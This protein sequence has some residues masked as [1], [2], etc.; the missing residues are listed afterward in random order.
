MSRAAEDLVRR[1]VDAMVNEGDLD[2]ADEVFS[3]DLAAE[4]RRWVA[5]FRASFTDV[6]MRVVTLVVDGDQV[7]GRFHCSGTHTGTWLGHPPT[8]R[9]FDDVD[10][11][12]FFRVHDARIVEM[13]G[14][15]DTAE[16]LRQ[17]GLA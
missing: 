12:Y 10:E 14:L 17:L 7:A 11:V 1:W 15:E 6:R 4:A 16:R 8:G 5:P 9:R 2:V 3:P 13:W